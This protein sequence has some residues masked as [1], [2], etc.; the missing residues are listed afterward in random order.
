MAI[1]NSNYVNTHLVQ[2]SEGSA[3]DTTTESD[4][5]DTTMDITS[6]QSA[7][8]DETQPMRTVPEEWSDADINIEGHEQPPQKNTQLAVRRDAA[9]RPGNPG[10]SASSRIGTEGGGDSEQPWDGQPSTSAQKTL[11]RY[12]LHTIVKRSTIPGAGLGLFLQEDAKKGDRVARYSGD[13]L[14]AY[15]ASISN[16]RYLF[17][18]NKN[19]LLYTS[20]SPRDS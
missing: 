9:T 2:Q 12:A 6:E 16:S 14:D 5:N 18:V 3:M 10:H 8:F 15:E 4:M 7:V 20:P 17:Q 13:R 1:G 19:C 11:P